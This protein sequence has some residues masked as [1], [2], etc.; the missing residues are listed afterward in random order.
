MMTRREK[1]STELLGVWQ[2]VFGEEDRFRALVECVD[3]SSGDR[4][5]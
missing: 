4:D 1:D 3:L 5:E 2:A